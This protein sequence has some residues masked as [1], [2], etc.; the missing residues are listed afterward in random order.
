MIVLQGGLQGCPIESVTLIYYTANHQTTQLDT[1]KFP[2]S[3]NVK[4]PKSDMFKNPN[5]KYAE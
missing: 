2:T 5:Y 4:P 1:Y 3:Q